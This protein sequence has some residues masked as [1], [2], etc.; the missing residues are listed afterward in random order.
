M[1]CQVSSV[2]AV[3]LLFGTPVA[4]GEWIQYDNPGS[5]SDGHWYR[6]TT[7]GALTWQ[8]AKVDA[9]NEGGYLVTINDTAENQW[10]LDTFSP[11]SDLGNSLWIGFTDEGNEGTWTWVEDPSLCAYPGDCY[12]NW[13][14][15]EPNDGGTGEDYALM[16]TYRESPRPPGTWNDLANDGHV[17]HGVIEMVPEPAALSLLALGAVALLRRKP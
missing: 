2:A 16:Y 8:Q 14:G 17:F 15:P 5:P 7:Q 11:L 3:V 10:V 6:L 12:T 4:F 1:L 9:E 13:F